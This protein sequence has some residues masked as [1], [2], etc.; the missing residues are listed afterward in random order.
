[1]TLVSVEAFPVRGVNV[2]CKTHINNMKDMTNTHICCISKHD[3]SRSFHFADVTFDD[4]QKQEGFR[5]HHLRLQ[6]VTGNKQAATSLM[7]ISQASK[8]FH[9]SS[10]V[11][12]LLLFSVI[13]S[14]R[15]QHVETGQTSNQSCSK[16][17]L[18]IFMW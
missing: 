16:K 7:D 6:G 17:T 11:K 3:A 4:G 1:M 10:G 12:I 9:Y 18:N 2:G 8:A 15:L 14:V 5:F 13:S